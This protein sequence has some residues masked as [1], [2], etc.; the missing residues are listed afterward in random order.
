V[1]ATRTILSRYIDILIARIAAISKNKTKWN[2]LPS[3]IKIKQVS[4]QTSIYNNI[5]NVT[6]INGFLLKAGWGTKRGEN[7]VTGLPGRPA[8]PVPFLALYNQTILRLLSFYEAE[9]NDKTHSSKKI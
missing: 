8:I 4:G 9:P 2:K 6:G 5:G 3:P 7:F 1:L